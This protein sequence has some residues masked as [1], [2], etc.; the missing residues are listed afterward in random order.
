[1]RG[2]SGSASWRR[3]RWSFWIRWRRGP[4]APPSRWARTTCRT[5]CWR[6]TTRPT[7]GGASWGCTKR[8]ASPEVWVE[9]PEGGSPRR[10]PGLTVHRRSAE[11]YRPVSASVALPGWTTA[12]IHACLQRGR[13]VGV[14]LRRAGTGRPR[15]GRARRHRSGRLMCGWGRS[16]AK[17]ARRAVRKGWPPVVP[18]GVRR[19][20]TRSSATAAWTSPSGWPPGSRVMNPVVLAAPPR[21]PVATRRICWRGWT[22]SGVSAG[23]RARATAERRGVGSTR[24]RTVAPRDDVRA[25][26]RAGSPN[27]GRL[28]IERSLGRCTGRHES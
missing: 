18:R 20:F 23:G 25:V 27:R 7:C 10:R 28:T 13:A 19:S 21:W 11:G 16:V 24:A 14:D 5:W 2:A 15:A 8:G 22:S 4:A 17:R 26:R 6:S 9:V 1:M 12:E 3:T